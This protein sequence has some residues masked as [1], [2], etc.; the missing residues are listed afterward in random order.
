MPPSLYCVKTGEKYNSKEEMLKLR[1]ISDNKKQKIRYWRKNYNYDLKIDD[2]ESFNE[3]ANI[4]RYIYKYHD[5]LIKY[6][7]NEKQVFE[8]DDLDIYVKNHKFFKRSIPYLDY[9]KTLKKIESK[10]EHNEPI[11]ITF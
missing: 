4:M 2:Y 10:V 11:V 3:I 1:R 6:I 5:F 9:I 7:P 8:K